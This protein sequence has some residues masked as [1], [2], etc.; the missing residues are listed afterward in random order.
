M[1]TYRRLLGIAVPVMW[2]LSN[3]I[4]ASA[5]EVTKTMRWDILSIKFEVTGPTTRNLIFGPGGAGSPQEIDGSKIRLTGSGTFST[6]DSKKVTGGG[7]W[8]TFDNK[9]NSTGKGTY[10]V[11][12]LVRFVP[13]PGRQLESFTTPTGIT[14]TQ[15]DTI[16]NLADARG[17]IGVFRVEF[18]DENSDESQGLLTVNCHLNTSPREV[19]GQEGVAV[20]KGFVNYF[21]YQGPIFYHIIPE[22]DEEEQ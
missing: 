1:R 17:G 16:G 3:G 10:K 12:S 18:T 8:E 9:G 13:V 4:V 6:R 19:Q 11:V 21:R 14:V 20:I 7:T 22:G 15:V 5:Q 2:L